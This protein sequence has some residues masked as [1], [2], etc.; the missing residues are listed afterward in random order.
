MPKIK[1]RDPISQVY[2]AIDRYVRANGGKV[3]VI[4]GIELQEWPDDR[5]LNFKIAVKCIGVK[6]KFKRTI[7]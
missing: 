3:A 1:G 6:P 2:R 5:K 7:P 4:G